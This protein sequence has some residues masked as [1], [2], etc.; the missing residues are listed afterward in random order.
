L[1][2]LER[3]R[4]QFTPDMAARKQAALRELARTTLRTS[5]QVRRLHEV[6]CFM[7]A[8][9][10][11]AGVLRQ[12]EQLLN[13]FARRR[14][15]RTHRDALAHSGIA[16]TMMG[17]PFFYPTAHWLSRNWPDALLLDRSDAIAE[18]SIAKSLPALMGMLENHA[19][20]ESHLPG[21]KAL[22][23]M[24]GRRTDATFLLDRIAAMPGDGFTREAFYDLINPSCELQPTHGTPTRTT[25]AYGKAP[26]AWQ[27]S[28][29]RHQRPDLRSEILRAPRTIR[30]APSGEAQTL[31]GLAREA[32]VTRCRDLDAFAYG[33]EDDVWLCDDGN[34]LAF[35]L[36]G[37]RPERRTALPAIYGGLTLKNGVPIGYHQADFLG[38]SAAVSFN[39]FETFRGG[40]S[41]ITFARLLAT[42]HAFGGVSSFTVEP[43]Q[44]GQGNDEGIESGAWWFYFKF[45]F[46]PRARAATQRAAA[47]ARRQTAKPGY[48]SSP[49]TL[50]RLA[51][52]HLFLDLDPRKP[53][54]L[55]LPTRIGLHV[56]A[57]L[58]RLAP[59]SRSAAADYADM[60]AR[61]ACGLDSL[62]GFAPAE[63]VA[64]TRLAPL[65]AA[66]PMSGWR[67][68]DRAALVS[69]ARAKGARSERTYV[70]RSAGFALLEGALATWCT[71]TA[72]HRAS[73]AASRRVRALRRSD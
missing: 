10:D 20:R 43:Y 19:L 29:L 47:E 44:L 66:L 53:A 13:D 26:R 39:T 9:A 30:R 2:A 40:E 34:G 65:F 25:A 70:R 8:H 7:R 33:N 11:D 49:E 52:H 68:S 1:T 41:A 5:E 12:V 3:W 38:R 42:L 17:Y 62:R 37:M 24:R 58:A 32:M 72:G 60:A 56:A 15:L 35:V 16:G 45:G 6:L 63:R 50:R 55:L 36:V 69:L 67:D 54:P 59:D 64:W 71:P 31:I 21:Y 73:D 22:D 57:T 48:R 27:T 46:R 4:E 51:E 28:P 14:D 23:A 18:E 61:S